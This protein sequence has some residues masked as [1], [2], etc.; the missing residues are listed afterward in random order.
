M[1]LRRFCQQAFL[2]WNSQ[3]DRIPG[4]R[5]GSEESRGERVIVMLVPLVFDWPRY[6]G[7]DRARFT[8]PRTGDASQDYAPGL[9]QRRCSDSWRVRDA[10]ATLRCQRLEKIVHLLS[11]GTDR[12]AR[13]PSR[14]VRDR[15]QLARRDVLGLGGK[16]RGYG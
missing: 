8:G 1:P 12:N 10:R 16:A 11:S 14:I 9:Y 2:R 5:T 13:Q 4:S 15:A 3:Q 7:E 6:L